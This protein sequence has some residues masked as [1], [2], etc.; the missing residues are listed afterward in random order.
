M[1]DTTTL[2]APVPQAPAPPASDKVTT[3]TTPASLGDTASDWNGLVIAALTLIIVIFACYMCVHLFK[4]RRP[5]A[6]CSNQEQFLG[7]G[8]YRPAC[9]SQWL[10][11]RAGC[12]GT[13]SGAMPSIEENYPVSWAPCC[14][15]LGVPPPTYQ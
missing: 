1:S 8:Q 6:E 15:I 12:N 14:G 11:R 4:A 3:M 9:S 5:P 10:E 7:G 13:T 2:A